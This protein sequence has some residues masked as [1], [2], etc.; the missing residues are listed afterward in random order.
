MYSDT[1]KNMDINLFLKKQLQSK[2]VI[3]KESE[4]KVCFETLSF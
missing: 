2:F 3:W 1:Q 4:K